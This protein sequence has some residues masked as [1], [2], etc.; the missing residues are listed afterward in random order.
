M[1]E[2]GTRT[3]YV[4]GPDA[5]DQ[6]G[7]CRCDAC[8]TANRVFAAGCRQRVLHQQ[9]GVAQP[10]LI[11]A[12]P[13]RDHVRQLTATGLGWKRVAE[14]AGVN[15]STLG[16]LLYG[17]A[18]RGPARRIRRDT[19]ARLLAVTAVPVADGA[20]VNAA[21]TQRRLQALVTLGWSQSELARQLGM[22]PTN[23]TI[24]LSRDLVTARRARAA[25]ALYEEL[26]DQLPAPQ[27]R[28]QRSGV[29]RAR[30]HAA[31]QGW[32][33]PAAWDDD[34]IDLPDAELEAEL[35]LRAAAMTDIEAQRCHAAHYKDG[36][37]S[38]L[39]VAGALE[40]GRRRAA[41]RTK[42][43]PA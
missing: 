5:N 20:Y 22:F 10:A 17:R 32:L 26:W 27:T 14:L 2:H 16:N 12:Q 23:F 6:P 21:G 35:A 3:R 31:A 39:I 24:M 40:H 34:L 8:R 4:N 9:W 28:T 38:P 13:A 33:P 37:R 42:R 11:D 43:V 41:M 7:P 19:A 30:R 25:R 36:D 29:T 1:R 15:D 18:G